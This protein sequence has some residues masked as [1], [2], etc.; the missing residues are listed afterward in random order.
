[1]NRRGSQCERQGL[2]L[3]HGRSHR[4]WRGSKHGSRGLL[5]GCFRPSAAKKRQQEQPS[6]PEHRKTLQRRSSTPLWPG[7]KTQ[8]TR[9]RR[10]T[11]SL[12]RS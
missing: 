6:Q 12:A 4:N 10:Q 2:A 11:A 7:A 5:Q 9:H 1:M 8:A 3:G